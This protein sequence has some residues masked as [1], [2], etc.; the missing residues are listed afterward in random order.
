MMELLKRLEKESQ[1]DDQNLL[2]TDDDVDEDAAA[3]LAHRLGA[4]D[5]CGPRQYPQCAFLIMTHLDSTSPDDLWSMLTPEERKKFMKA[6]DNPS[7]ELAQQLLASEALDSERLEPW[8][9]APSLNDG[10][11]ALPTKRYGVKP[12]AMPIPSAIPK[13]PVTGSPLLY[14]ICAMW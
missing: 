5:I 8:W 3:D 11:Q 12:E 13:M 14:N 6:L 2:E 9:E 10:T 4:M 7:S 1:E